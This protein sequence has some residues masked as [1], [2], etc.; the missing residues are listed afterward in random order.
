MIVY[1][2][3]QT[4]ANPHYQALQVSNNIRQY[5]FLRSIVE[6]SVAFN[7]CFLSEHVIKAFNYHAIACLH[8]HAGEYRPCEVE[9]GTHKPPAAFRVHGL[10][11]DFVNVVNRSWQQADP[12]ALSAFVLWRLNYIHP[13]I[14]GNGR[15]ARVAC[16]FVL[17]V[18]A[19]GWLAGTPILPDLIR[20]NRD[21]YVAALAAADSSITKGPLDLTQL[22]ALLEKL[23]GQQMSGVS[24]PVNP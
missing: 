24:P 8:S 17:C 11:E 5:D 22:H 9:V 16:Y 1:D 7:R 21:A 14:N 6:T 23:L 3:T 10:M 15:T 19:G 2:L 12:L 4:E 20:E 13:F 18:S